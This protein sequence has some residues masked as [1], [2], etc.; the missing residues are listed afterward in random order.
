M[1]AK[2]QFISSIYLVP[3]LLLIGLIGIILCIYFFFQY[4]HAKSLLKNP[5]AAVQEEGKQIVDIIRT[6]V[7][8]PTDELPTIATVTDVGKLVEQP[9]FATARDGDKVLVFGKAHKV[10]LYRPSTKKVINISNLPSQASAQNTPSAPQTQSQSPIRVVVLN[11]SKQDGLAGQ[12]A[13]VLTGTNKYVTVV[14]KY[15]AHKNTYEKTVVVYL[16]EQFKKD[17]E[18]IASQ[19]NGLAVSSL[20]QGE[21]V[22]DA[23]IV[24]IAAQ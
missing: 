22:E 24:V 1:A 12:T 10:I 23:D 8:V 21:T 5:T 3:G 7:D 15:S 19:L 9:F 4:Q 11:G 16:S 20:P 13:D 18:Q 14:K 17:A 6:V 2:K